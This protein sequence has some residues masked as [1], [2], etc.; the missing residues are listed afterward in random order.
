MKN[1][2]LK[3]MLFAILAPNISCSQTTKETNIKTEKQSL[4]KPYNET[5]NA[6]ERIKELIT[7][8]QLENK[9]IILQAG[10][11]W[12]IW[13]LRFNHFVETTT[14]LKEIVDKNYLYYHLNF[15]PKNKNEQA[16]QKYAE[17]RKKLGYPFFVILDKNGKR[18]HIQE[19]SIFEEGQGYNLEKVKSFFETWVPKD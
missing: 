2:I 12:C 14:E 18:I 9:N 5:E 1:F 7:K 6:D 16:F 11:N 8:A 10:G 17:D 3:A 13:C 15:S 4:P 19:S